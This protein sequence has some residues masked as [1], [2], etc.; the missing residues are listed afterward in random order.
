MKEEKSPNE[1][2]HKHSPAKG[3]SPCKQAQ[4]EVLAKAAQSKGMNQ[5]DSFSLV[6][7]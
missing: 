2:E 6:H 1:E 3:F 7:P 5:L 4:P